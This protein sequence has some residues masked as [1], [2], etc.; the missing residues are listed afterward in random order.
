MNTPVLLQSQADECGL[1]CI[2]MVASAYGSEQSL[3]SLRER[4]AALDHGPCL[5][6]VLGIARALD[7]DARPLRVDLAELGRL[8]LPAILHWRLDHFVV[9][10]KVRKSSVVIHDPAAGKRQISRDEL[11][12]S[13]SGVVIELQPADDFRRR[14]GDGR[15]R[16]RDLLSMLTGFRRYFLLMFVLLVVAQLFALALPVGTQLLIDEVLLGSDR[17][18]LGATLAGI[19]AVLLAAVVFETLRKR[20]ALGAGI[21]VS[22]AA[23]RAAIARMFRLPVPTI[24]KR[25]VADLVSR[26]ESLL[27]IQT[28]LTETLVTGT[29][30]LVTLAL[31]LIVMLLYSPLITLLSV[32]A[33]ISVG[34]IQACMLPAIRTHNLEA[35]VATAAANQS[36]IESLRSYGAVRAISMADPRCLHWQNG[37][38]RASDARARRGLLTIQASALQSVIAAI[39]QLAFLG[40]GVTLVGKRQVTIGILF[41]LF[42]LRGRLNQAAASLAGAIHELYLARS[43]L[44]RIGEVLALPGEREA[45]Q[46]ALRRKLQG[47]VQCDRLVF[48]YPGGKAVLD[49][50]SCA[51]DAGERVVLCGPSGVGKSTLLKVLSTELDADTGS[52]LFDGYDAS[53][54][55]PANLR[56][57]LALVRQGD[58]LMAGSVAANVA[59]FSPNPDVGRLREAAEL[60]CIWEDIVR[61]PMQLD[62]PLSGGGYGLSGGQLQRL[63]IARAVY[64]RPRVLLLDEATNQLDERTETKVIDRLAGTGI[65]IISVVHSAHGRAS[66]GRPIEIGRRAN[67]NF[68]GSR[69]ACLSALT[70]GNS[71]GGPG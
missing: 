2:A 60:A 28:L 20:Y 45:P 17:R 61:L 7:L 26:V 34:I 32:A 25:P 59:G 55:D 10:T 30:Q 49:D 71:D 52:V 70:N 38:R 65:T 47:A 69:P 15:L 22:V 62:T 44:D 37:F 40:V 43:H 23:S 1:A 31:T 56:S 42:S 36:L 29:V 18:W 6:T 19:G 57:Q 41:A 21:E 50:F 12:R 58:R 54:W 9:L 51:I 33:L 24:E 63:L 3:T 16:L 27:P 11:S 48:R 8:R 13:F 68:S 5:R 4:H 66:S 39:D 46:T 64:R 35:V 14:Q 53:L 67:G